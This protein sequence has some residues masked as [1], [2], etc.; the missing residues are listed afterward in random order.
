MGNYILGCGFKQPSMDLTFDSRFRI[1][2]YGENCFFFKTL[3][4]T[5]DATLMPLHFLMP[6]IQTLICPPWVT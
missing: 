5:N 3:E 2:Y 1:G 4:S 6:W